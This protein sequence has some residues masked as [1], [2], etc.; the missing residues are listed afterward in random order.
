VRLTFHRRL[1]GNRIGGIDL[2]FAC[3]IASASEL[4]SPFSDDD[5]YRKNDDIAE[6]RGL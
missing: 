5:A 3:N 6:L 1:V 4:N 2:R